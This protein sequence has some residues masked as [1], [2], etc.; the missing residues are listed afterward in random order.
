MTLVIAKRVQVQGRNKIYNKVSLSSDSRI[1]FGTAGNIDYGVKIFSIPTKISLPISSETGK[2]EI[3]YN[4]SLGLAV[5]GSAIHSYTVK[6][7]I[8]DILQHLQY[9]PNTMELSMKN[10][11]EFVLKFF[12]KT[13]LDFGD[14]LQK[15]SKCILVLAGYCAKEKKICV[16]KFCIDDSTYPIKPYCEEILVDNEID[17]FGSGAEEAKKIHQ[18]NKQ[19][20]E[21]Q[22]IRKVIADKNIQ[23]VGGGIQYGDICCDVNGEYTNFEVFG[24]QDYALNDDG[25]FKEYLHTLRGLTFYKDEFESAVN[26]FHINLT[27]KTPFTKEIE[28]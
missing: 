26:D 3:A 18:I 14:I 27:F 23:S 24:V 22:I 10:I 4:N 16:F 19:L 8:S 5:V 17:F 7:S 9:I 21:F 28:N 20:N 15:E 25:T 13:S 2:E 1:N 11:A 12:T 6:E